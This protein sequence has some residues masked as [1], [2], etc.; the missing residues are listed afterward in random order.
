MFL[1]S[2]EQ[3]YP[4]DDDDDITPAKNRG[5]LYSAPANKDPMSDRYSHAVRYNLVKS[6]AENKDTMSTRHSPVYSAPGNRDP[7]SDRYSPAFTRHDVMQVRQ[8]K[9]EQV[10]QD[11]YREWDSPQRK[12]PPPVSSQRRDDFPGVAN[13]PSGNDKVVSR[14]YAQQRNSPPDL[15]NGPTYPYQNGFG[16][17][18]YDDRIGVGGD[19]PDVRRRRGVTEAPPPV[20]SDQRPWTDGGVTRY[21]RSTHDE[22]ADTPQSG[23]LSQAAMMVRE[24]YEDGEFNQEVAVTRGSDIIIF[25]WYEYF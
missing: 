16:G 15:H 4:M 12:S 24:M 8:S 6:A 5:K 25:L 10:R 22:R 14:T 19:D 18:N 3:R 17:G 11:V 2:S 1:F 21:Y 20:S 23:R 7:T 13:L 9:D